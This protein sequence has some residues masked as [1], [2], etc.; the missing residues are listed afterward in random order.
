MRLGERS[1]SRGV[2][3]MPRWILTVVDHRAAIWKTYPVQR[4]V[5]DAADERTARQQVAQ[6]APDAS[7]PN[8]WLDSALTCCERVDRPATAT[9]KS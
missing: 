7:A 4:I 8:P 3:W 5:V 1:D 6:A 9:A 2:K